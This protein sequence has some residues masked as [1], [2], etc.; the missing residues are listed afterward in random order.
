MGKKHENPIIRTT[1]LFL[2]VFL[3][4]ASVGLF[5]KASAATTQS[6]SVGI[7]GTIPANPPT[8]A[9]TINIPTNGQSFS[10]LPINVGGLCKT[11]LLVE[12]F[13]NNV[14]AGAV[15]CTGGSYSMQIDLFDSRNDLVARQY[16]ELNQA[17]PDSNVVTVT[18]NS[19]FVGSGPRLSLTTLYAKRGADPG[20]VLSW[21]ITISGGKGPYAI[22]IDWGDK[23]KTDLISRSGPGNID[24]QHTYDKSGVYNI[25]IKATDANGQSAFLQV[26][27]VANGPIQQSTAGGATVNAN[28]NQAVPL[29]VWVIL[30]LL[31][32]L[33]L[34]TFWL[35]KKHQL[36]KI[37]ANLRRGDS[38]V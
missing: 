36:Q 35:G 13:K 29:Y 23:S 10:S 9:P 16:D 12:V 19:G 8:Q 25:I 30:I 15:V 37:R 18:F 28:Q 1:V 33:I 21:P 6:G 26:V 5:S 3:I 7:E 4:A 17:S 34:S 14:F 22:S 27:G 20:A 11:G 31:L 38:P 24:L 2:G 32:P